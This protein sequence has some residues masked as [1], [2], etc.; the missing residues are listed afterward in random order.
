MTVLIDGHIHYAGFVGNDRLLQIIDEYGYDGIAL[1][2]I[3][4]V[5]GNP[6]E[7]DA[8]LFKEEC[9]IPVYIFGGISRSLYGL[10]KSQLSQRLVD[11]IH[12]LLDM[13]CTGIKMLEGKPNIRKE[14]NI[15]DFDDEVWEKYWKYL[16]QKQIPIY[17]HV[18][19]PAEFWD[20][21]KISEFAIKAGWYYDETYINN[22]DQYRQ[23]LNVLEKHPDL[24]ILFPHFFFFSNQLER[25]DAILTRFS[26]VRIDITPGIE[27]YYNLS[28]QKEKAVRFFKK[29][30]NR[31][32]YGTDIG[33]RAL[34][35]KEPK[36]LSIEESR[37]RVALIKSF[38]ETEDTY[39]LFPDGYFIKGDER[40]MNGLGLPEEILKKIYKDNFL[41]FIN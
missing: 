13:G 20:R 37:A 40:V 19:D 34:V 3:P 7:K 4:D 30:Q 9:Q 24:R 29:Y 39:T 18:N 33:G 36:K 38:L 10:T 41:T 35:A 15:P 28:A 32:C 21:Q 31:I 5:K 8:F 25:L 12:R 22:E 14:W 6:V 23:I 11:E 27:L 26:Q 17:M 2:C 16:E 1:Q